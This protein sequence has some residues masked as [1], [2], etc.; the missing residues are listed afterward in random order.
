MWGSGETMGSSQR[1]R[2]D[3]EGTEA[4]PPNGASHYSPAVRPKTGSDHLTQPSG[5]ARPLLGILA[6]TYT[7]F[8]VTICPS[9]VL[10]ALRRLL[11]IG[12]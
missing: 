6:S 8:P 3:K 4:V 9:A 10:S 11:A 5:L 7:P 2:A 12:I 1:I